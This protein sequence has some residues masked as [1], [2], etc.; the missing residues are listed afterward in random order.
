VA[1]PA[2]SKGFEQGK[3]QWSVSGI[4]TDQ[5]G[6]AQV[7]VEVRLF[8]KDLKRSHLLGKDTTDGNGRFQIGYQTKDFRRMLEKNPDLFVEIWSGKKKLYT[9]EKDIKFNAK[10]VEEFKVILSAEVK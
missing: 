6:Q 9:G 3:D 4:V 2:D 1:P 5:K 8:D 10:R 7:G